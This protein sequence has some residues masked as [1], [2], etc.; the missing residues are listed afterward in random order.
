MASILEVLDAGI[1][2]TP[3]E[4][5]EVLGLSKHQINRVLR[6]MLEEGTVT[7]VR[8]SSHKIG[9]PHVFYTTKQGASS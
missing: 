6:A 5:S 9:E 2:V 3:R 1:P 8:K 7:T 4:L